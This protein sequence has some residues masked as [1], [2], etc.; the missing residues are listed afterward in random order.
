MRKWQCSKIKV[1]E[2]RLTVC[3]SWCGKLVTLMS[4]QYCVLS[5]L[6]STLIFLQSTR[7][8]FSI[9]IKNKRM[10]ISVHS[11]TVNW[12]FKAFINSN[13]VSTVNWSHKLSIYDTKP[14]DKRLFKLLLCKW[15]YFRSKGPLM[16]HEA[17]R[18][19]LGIS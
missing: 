14:G 16:D 6:A 1:A 7:H 18:F 9:Q 12:W 3:R 15:P 19:D 13:S 8:D 5:P 17:I 11:L 4:L 2:W 10:N